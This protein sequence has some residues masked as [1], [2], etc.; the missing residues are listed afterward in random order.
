MIKWIKK[1]LGVEALEQQVTQ[2]NTAKQQADQQLAEANRELAVFREKKAEDEARR[3]SKDPWVEI[4][5]ADFSDVR[6]FRIELDWNEAFVQHLKESG[7]KGTSEE[8]IVQK[9]LAFLYQDLVEKLEAK[10]VDKK[11]EKGTVSDFV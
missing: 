3:N 9:W 2:L 1:L 4:K 10:V 8:E 6:G 7:I 11:D 5:S